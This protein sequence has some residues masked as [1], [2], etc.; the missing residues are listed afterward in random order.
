[1]KL[2]RNSCSGPHLCT[3]TWIRTVIGL[4]KI[5]FLICQSG[6]K[7]ISG[8]IAG[9]SSGPLGAQNRD[10]RYKLNSAVNILVV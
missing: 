8:G 2:C 7:E 4:L 3:R 6:S 1:M 9:N 5:P 10:P